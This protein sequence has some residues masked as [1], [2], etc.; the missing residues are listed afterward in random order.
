M[1][2]KNNNFKKEKHMK[3][4]CKFFEEKNIG[5]VFDHLIG[6]CTGLDADEEMILSCF[7]K[8]KDL[9]LHIHKDCDFDKDTGYANVVCI[10]TKQNGKYVDDTE[11]IFVS[12]GSLYHQL[13]RIYNYENF[14][15]L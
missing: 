13:E 11:D 12:D 6:L 15:T 10:S 1:G 8:N 9:E 3:Y 5:E 2:I 4:N 7:G 14:Q